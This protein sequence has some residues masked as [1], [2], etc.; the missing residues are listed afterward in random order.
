MQEIHIKL[1][2]DEDG[3][4]EVLV[5][6]IIDGNKY[7]FLLDTGSGKSTIKSDEFISSF[8][9]IGNVKGNGVF[10]S[11]EEEKITVPNLEVGP[12]KKKDFAMSRTQETSPLTKNLIGMDFLKDH[13]FHF[14]FDKNRV[15]VDDDLNTVNKLKELIL[16]KKYHPYVD[17][18][19]GTEKASAVWDT[20][21]GMTVVDLTFIDKFP[22]HF[23]ERGTSIGTDA[24]G[25]TR[26]TPM[27]LMKDV[28]IG[29]IE[30]P[31]HLVVGV[32][33]SHVNASTEIPMNLILGY[34][35]MIKANWFFDFPNKKWSII[36]M[37][38]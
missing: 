2:T 22:H 28:T 29:D 8:S 20:G 34:T 10:S 14:Y 9:S 26:E 23:Q 33:L 19:F 4:A 3:S 7:C 36:N 25:T 17:V 16:G 37:L 21:A 18:Y 38:E 24:T 13:R 31:S 27:Y 1:I 12:I 11:F 32:D 35:T 5:D 15:I 30:F 6:G